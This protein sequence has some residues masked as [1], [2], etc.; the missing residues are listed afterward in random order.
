ML[1]AMQKLTSRVF[2]H[3]YITYTLDVDQMVSYM[4]RL[5]RG[6]A[7]KKYKTVLVDCKETA[8]GVYG[9]QWMLCEAKGVTM[10]HLWTWEK[11]YGT[12]AGS[13]DY[14]DVDKCIDFEK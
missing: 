7:L 10:D 5:L 14:L 6:E 8:K 3:L 4:Q 2:E 11:K 1:R 9:Y 13:I 12:D